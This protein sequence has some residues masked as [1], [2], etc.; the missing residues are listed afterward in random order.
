[1]IQVNRQPEQDAADHGLLKCDKWHERHRLMALRRFGVAITILNVLGHFWLGFEQSWIQPFVAI[2]AAY[3]ME[4]LLELVDSATTKRRP[5]FLGGYQTFVDYLIPAHISGMAC[6]MLLYAND[7]LMPVAF[8]AV[9]AIASKH[10]LRIYT[11]NGPRHIFN[12]S[13]FGITLTLLLFPSVGIAQPYQFTENLDGMADWILPAM[14]MST[15]TLF[16]WRF[17]KRLPLISA[18]LAT[19]ALQAVIRHLVFGTDVSAALMPMT[20][21]A[22]I[23][24]TFYMITD[25]P[26]T[27]HT[28]RGQLLF[29]A[30]VA[31]VYGLLMALH[32]VFGLF[33]A[34]T[35]TSVLRASVVSAATFI[36]RARNC[37]QTEKLLVE[38]IN[39]E[40][41]IT[42]LQ[43]SK[44]GDGIAV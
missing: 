14:I 25:P 5:K 21:V 22:F 33:F 7:R 36:D 28:A 24:F 6:S 15:G 17:T 40:P 11:R 8:A 20:G 26:T 2:A 10:V 23:L 42:H 16:N 30:A 32:V 35:I 31:S 3:S 41:A 19:F 29:G 38:A 1:M 44:K 18:W 9:V 43:E 34:L 37:E 12:P 4:L 27:P 39:E 13:N